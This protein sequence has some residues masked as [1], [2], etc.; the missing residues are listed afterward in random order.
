MENIKVLGFDVAELG[1]GMV[2]KYMEI[3]KLS[4]LNRR[5]ANNLLCNYCKEMVQNVLDYYRDIF[6]DNITDYSEKFSVN[7][8]INDVWFESCSLIN[9]MWYDDVLL[10]DNAD[11]IFEILFNEKINKIINNNK[12]GIKVIQKYQHIINIK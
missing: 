11:N 7:K 3:S 5:E 10:D 6:N 4:T 8:I 9:D 1:N 2:D 12:E